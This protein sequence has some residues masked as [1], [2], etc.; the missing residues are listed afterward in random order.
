VNL[1]MPEIHIQIKCEGDGFPSADELESR[2]ELEDA[3]MEAEVGEI[4]DAGGG[5]G[6]M[7]IYIDV[8]DVAGAMTTITELVKTLGLSP[9]TTVKP[10]TAP[11]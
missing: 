8:G 7:D 6:V 9:R 2:N 3:L 11:N 5:M 10:V 1:P 4:V